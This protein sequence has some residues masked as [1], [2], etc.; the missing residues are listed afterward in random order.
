MSSY[1]PNCII[2]F[3]SSRWKEILGAIIL[4]S[5]LLIIGTLVFYWNH[6]FHCQIS[7]KP[8]D[9]GM[10][11]DFIGGT[12][13]PLL[14]VINICITIWLTII[15]T[16]FSNIN[17]DKQII[18]QKQVVKIQLRHEALKELRLNLNEKFE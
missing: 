1:L 17:I 4:F 12:I 11:G 13:N 15:I 2:E 7:E 18:V 10:F 3:F 14:A 6:F 16:K 9:W 5:I 8:S